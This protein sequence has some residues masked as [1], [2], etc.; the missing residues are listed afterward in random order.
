MI[1]DYTEKVIRSSAILTG[2]YVAGTVITDGHKYDQLILHIDFTKGSL[3]SAQM[4]IEFSSDGVTYR[5]E[6][7]QAIS[8]G[9]S[10][11]SNGSHTWTDDGTKRYLLD[12]GDPFIRVS[13]KGTGVVTSSLCAVT[14]LLIRRA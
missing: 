10:T 2:S 5:E 12:I 7:F 4:L 6:T 11:L 14:A 13:V 8:G 1:Q 9:T 3:T